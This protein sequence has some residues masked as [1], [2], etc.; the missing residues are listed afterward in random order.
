MWIRVVVYGRLGLRGRGGP[1]E[2]RGPFLNFK[3]GDGE[4]D[5]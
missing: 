2:D 5:G 3:I 1:V 4:E